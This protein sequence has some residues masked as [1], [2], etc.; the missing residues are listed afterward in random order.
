[1]GLGQ[2]AKRLSKAPDAYPVEKELLKGGT[3]ITSDNTKKEAPPPTYTAT[4]NPGGPSL[5]EINANFAN[6]RIE[7]IPPPFPDTDI[8]LAHLK[9]LETL[10]ILKQEVGYTD[11]AF[12]LWDS[13]APGT[14]E[15]VANDETARNTRNEALSK[16]REKRWALYVARAVRRFELWWA[17]VLCL[18]EQGQIL[19]QKNML[20]KV[21]QDFPIAGRVQT[22][23]TNM[24]PPLGKFA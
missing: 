24:L 12:D 15:S 23:T 6:L 16:I 19:E 8:V 10:F 14:A 7:V 18:Y 1:M 9:L 20:G 22:W 21:F 5:D 3:S 13:R 17:K 2:F 4:A 11:G